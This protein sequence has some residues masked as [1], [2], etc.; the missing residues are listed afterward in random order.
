MSNLIQKFCNTNLFT[1]KCQATSVHFNKFSIIMWKAKYQYLS[2]TTSIERNSDRAY[3]PLLA[4]VIVPCVGQ[5]LDWHFSHQLNY[6]LCW[7]AP[8]VAAA[9]SVSVATNV[10][11]GAWWSVDWTRQGQTFVLKVNN[12]TQSLQRSDVS[13]FSTARNKTV[14]VYVGARPFNPGLY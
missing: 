7:V 12:L 4:Q 6:T 11:D 3:C 8:C 1:L 9:T 5:L 13:A 10:S 2:V 14:L